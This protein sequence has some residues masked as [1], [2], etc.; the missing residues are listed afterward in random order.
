MRALLVSSNTLL[1]ETISTS[2]Q[3]ENCI[4]LVSVAPDAAPETIRS[5]RPEVILLDEGCLTAA[6]METIW[7]AARQLPS[8]RVVLLSSL[9]NDIVVLDAAC[10]TLHHSIDLLNLMQ[11]RVSPEFATDSVAVFT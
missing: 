9:S 7:K 1:A 11:S 5:S 8:F 2:I 6:T 3:S 4:D 10:T